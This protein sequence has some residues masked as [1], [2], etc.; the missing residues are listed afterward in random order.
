[1]IWQ[2]SDCSH[3]QRQAQEAQSVG[4]Q[5]TGPSAETRRKGADPVS[6]DSCLFPSREKSYVPNWK[7][8]ASF[9]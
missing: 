9:K 1:M 4:T 8:L 7:H 2:G 6:P 5:E 3:S